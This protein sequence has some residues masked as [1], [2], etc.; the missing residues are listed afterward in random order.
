MENFNSHR[1]EPCK[2]VRFGM[3]LKTD[4][5]VTSKPPKTVFLRSNFY[6]DA[7]DPV[8]V[9][10]ICAS[11]IHPLITGRCK[12]HSAIA[13]AHASAAANTIFPVNV[14]KTLCGISFYADKGW[15]DWNVNA[16]DA[17]YQATIHAPPARRPQI[18][19]LSETGV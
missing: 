5:A 8:F 14:A 3:K 15:A 2:V 1:A 6:T 16:S 17:A 7:I 11:A 12:N 10:A 4:A 18:P 13:R 19:T 9:I